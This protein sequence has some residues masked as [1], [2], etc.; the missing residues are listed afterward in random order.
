MENTR[1]NSTLILHHKPKL[2]RKWVKFYI[3]HPN[4]G[5]T[6]YDKQIYVKEITQYF[7]EKDDIERNGIVDTDKYEK[8]I[9]D[10]KE[11]RIP[12]LGIREPTGVMLHYAQY[13]MEVPAESSGQPSLFLRW[14]SIK[15]VEWYPLTDWFINMTNFLD[16]SLN[17]INVSS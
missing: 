3:Y 6:Q 12:V 10:A 16:K 4:M 11:I 5:Q 8:L 14:N 1:L 15:P 13:E 9:Q 7:D 2:E 17:E